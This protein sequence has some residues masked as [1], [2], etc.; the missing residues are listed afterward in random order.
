MRR[1]SFLAGA[2]AGAA[3]AALWAL[4]PV[5]LASAPTDKRLVFVLLRGGLDGLAAFPATGDPHF[6][7]ARGAAMEQ[8][9]PLPLDDT[10]GMHPALAP[11]APLWD[12]RELL[13]VHAAAIP[14]R[15][16]SHFDGQNVLENGTTTP[17]GAATGWLGRAIAA[18]AD[19]SPTFAVGRT[20]PLVLRGSPR[21]AS[22]DPARAPEIDP[23]ILDR[24]TALYA[25]DPIFG[26]AL[27]E[28]VALERLLATHRAAVGATGPTDRANRKGRK[29]RKDEAA[30]AEVLG[31]LLAADEGPRIA[32]ADLGGWDTHVKQSATLASRL[33]DLAEVVA[34]LRRGLADRWADAVVVVATEFG[35]TVAGNG[36]GGT[37]HGVGSAA[38]VA[39]GRVAGGRVVADWPGLAPDRLLEGRDLRPTTDLR[40]VFAG[41]LRDHLGFAGDL[42]AVFPDPGRPVAPMADLIRS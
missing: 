14:Y 34:G 24:M 27:R 11:L 7:A 35:R 3:A 1:R 19:R 8:A 37:D 31:R 9:A 28:G 15:D 17:Y 10:F 33:P 40:A 42:G 38:I 23:A 30:G 39:G 2:G 36:T 21:T 20:V 18:D 26:P 29:G 16:R 5:A 25:D 12:R 13:V 22:A 41:V 32:V 4:P 6:A